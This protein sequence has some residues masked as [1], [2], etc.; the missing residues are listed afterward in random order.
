MRAQQPSSMQAIGVRTYGGPEVLHAVELAA[1]E[2]LRVVAVA[3]EQDEDWPRSRGADTFVARGDDIAQRVL[4]AVPGGV[5][6]VADSAMLHERITPPIRDNG[7]LAVL[8]FWDGDYLRESATCL[9]VERTE[10]LRLSSA[11]ARG[12]AHGAPEGHL[13]PGSPLVNGSV[14]ASAAQPV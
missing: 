9:P 11:T 7:R 5:D 4:D 13:S 12:R 6:A 1:A 10:L 14:R 2:G 8:R 3:S